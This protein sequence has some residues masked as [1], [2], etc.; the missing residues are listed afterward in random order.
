MHTHPCTRTHAHAHFPWVE[1]EKKTNKK[2]LSEP[3]PIAATGIN[4]DR[5][6]LFKVHQLIYKLS[7]L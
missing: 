5:L 3:I 1:P 2:N 7:N 4:S 6:N